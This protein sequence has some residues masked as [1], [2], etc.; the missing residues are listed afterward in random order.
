VG[1]GKGK[2][3]ARVRGEGEIDGVINE[4]QAWL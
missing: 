2:E 4:V 1:M 3:I